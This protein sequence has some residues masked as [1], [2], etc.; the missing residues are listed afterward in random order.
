MKLLSYL[1][2][3]NVLPFHLKYKVECFIFLLQ[4]PDIF[5]C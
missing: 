4:H 3:K 2:I 1:V 5:S